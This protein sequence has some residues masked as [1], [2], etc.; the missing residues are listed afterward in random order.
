MTENRGKRKA[1]EFLKKYRLREITPGQITDILEQSGYTV[2][3]F[4]SNKDSDTIIRE[5]KLRGYA[6]NSRGFTYADSN[7]RI[8]FVSEGLTAEEKLIV[9]CHEMGH[10]FC[11]HI[12]TSAII[13]S[14][15]TQEYEANEFVHRLLNPTFFERAGAAIRKHRIRTLL[16]SVLAVLAVIIAVTAVHEAHERTYYGEYYVTASGTKY[17]TEDCYII[18]DKTNVR[19][20]TNDDINKGKYEPCEICI[21]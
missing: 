11:G 21:H 8:V 10:I 6:D 4:G 7:Y 3:E 19:R 17:H 9:L 5:L 13:G 16:C 15:V 14:D 18:K 12:G 20:L 2:A 1:G